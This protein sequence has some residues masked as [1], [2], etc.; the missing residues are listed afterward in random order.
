MSLKNFPLVIMLNSCFI[1][2]RIAYLSMIFTVVYKSWLHLP[3]NTSF[4]PLL[5]IT[6]NIL[7]TIIYEL[8]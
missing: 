5:Y 1:A 8:I 3:S 4:Y 6:I 7:V 2:P